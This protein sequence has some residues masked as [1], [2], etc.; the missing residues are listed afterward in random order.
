VVDRLEV[1]LK[2]KEALQDVRG[3]LVVLGSSLVYARGTTL[4]HTE[5]FENKRLSWVELPSRYKTCRFA[6][7]GVPSLEF[8]EAP[9]DFARAKNPSV[10][11]FLQTQ[12]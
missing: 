9:G 4:D 1:R 6:F 7:R 12:P 10:T 3:R 5:G 11:L 8:T 2:D